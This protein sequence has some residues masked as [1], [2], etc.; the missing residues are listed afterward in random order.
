MSTGDY[1]GILMDVGR[2]AAS[3]GGGTDALHQKRVTSFPFNVCNNPMYDGSTM[4]FLA[5]AIWK[6]SPV[7]LLLTLLV[8]VEYRVALRYEE[9]FTAHIVSEVVFHVISH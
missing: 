6:Q 2:T 5:T 4:C 1:F 7:G 9:P 8:F 3:R